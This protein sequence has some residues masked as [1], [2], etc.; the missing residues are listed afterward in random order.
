MSR[1]PLLVGAHEAEVCAAA[2]PA[3]PPLLVAESKGGVAMQQRKAIR[4]TIWSFVAT[5]AIIGLPIWEA[6]AALGA[7]GG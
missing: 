2:R 7:G 1:Q 6:R 4:A 3:S 5:I